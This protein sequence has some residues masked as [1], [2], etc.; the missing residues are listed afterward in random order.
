MTV[1]VIGEAGV[2]AVL[3]RISNLA[4]QL[5]GEMDN[6]R[7]YAE[8]WVRLET[9]VDTGRLAG[10]LDSAIES[11]PDRIYVEV[12]FDATY[13]PYGHRYDQYVKG[14]GTQAWMHRGRVTT[15][16]DDLEAIAPAV[17]GMIDAAVERVV[18]SAA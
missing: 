7:R 10:N 11:E 16:A 15:I 18:E 6:V 13:G 2:N 1:E 12:F 14:E 5:E 9:P 17:I 3:T 8:D 4:P